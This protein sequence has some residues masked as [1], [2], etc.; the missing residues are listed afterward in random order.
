M[1]PRTRSLVP[2]VVLVAVLS[3]TVGA[4]QQKIYWADEVP[5]GWNGKWPAKFLTV[6]EKTNYTRTT[7][8]LDLQEFVDTLKW[9]SENVY[10]LN[11]FTTALR[12]VAPAIVLANPRSTSPQEA[13]K[14]GK[15]VM[16]L[17]GNIHPPEPEGTEALLLVMRDILFGSR[18]HL[19]DNQIVIILPIFNMDG[20]DTFATQDGT[21]HI[22]GQRSN[23]AGLDLNRDAV[24]LE[25]IEANGLYQ[26]V[27]NR[28]DPVLLVDLHL[29]GRVNHGYA[30]TYA[31]CTVPAAHPAPRAYTWDTLFPAVREAVRR[32]FGLETFT[33]C[34]ADNKWP[35]TV[36][37][38]D[39]AIWSVEA[40]FIVNDY[41]LRNRMAII[42]ETPG[43]PTF[44]RRIYAQYAYVLS[45]L[46]FTNA[47]AKEMQ[48][49]CKDADED[50]VTRVRA[51]ADSGG[52]KNWVAGKY[53]SWGKVDIL[54][55]R[56]N[57]AVFLPGTSVRGTAP[58]SASG[59]PEVIHDVE[60]LAKPVGTKD[61]PMPRG[62]LIP[63]ELQDLVAKLRTHNI[64]LQTLAQ[65]MKAT[66]E[67]FVVDKMVKPRGSSMT[68]LEGGFFGPATRE[69]PAGTY[70]LDMAQPMANAAFY[71][72]EPQSMDG[73]V[74][75]GLLDNHMRSLGVEQ[76][77]VVYPI[78]KYR[79][80]VK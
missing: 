61:A 34:L 2:A 44:E 39:N 12:K 60:H 22:V 4:Q 70:F 11:I 41:G 14:S 47:H 69:F 71:Y 5:K 62:Y 26:N 55:Y 65:S 9:N 13:V 77:P 51:Q 52:L 29:M 78:F 63:A 66:G 79:K 46:E 49:V 3:I 58:G 20:T 32:D 18:K 7:S 67:E 23:A 42:T 75:W 57:D 37:S 74:G 21:P 43:H 80:E 45:L 31:T 17:Q 53:E 56:T 6:P 36:W 15:P 8:T 24:K 38:H 30:N 33:H 1:M 40:K 64:R 16:F 48:K 72:L 73:F 27:L 28:W 76:H 19:L 25:S 54:A 50:T 10:V 59:P 68:T 35:P